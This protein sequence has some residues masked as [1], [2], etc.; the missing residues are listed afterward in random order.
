MRIAIVSTLALALAASGCKALGFHE[1]QKDITTYT[2]KA[3]AEFSTN[4]AK[5]EERIVVKKFTLDLAAKP[6]KAVMTL[7]NEGPDQDLFLA[8]VEFG[9]PAEAGSV[10]P[11]IPDFQSFARES[12]VK[13]AELEFTVPSSTVALDKYGPP[14]FARV[15]VTTGSS[16][17]MTTACEATSLGLKQG[18]TFLGGA[19][20][21]VDLE[22][23]LAAEKPN[24]RFTLQNVGDKGEIGTLMYTCQFFSRDGK[25]IP[26]GKRFYQLKALEKPLGKKGDK[27]TI[28]VNPTPDASVSLVG[29]K[30]VLFVTS[31]ATA[32]K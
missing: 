8:D 26:L 9:Y 11:Y 18:S 29:A 6:P 25:L 2:T 23:D 20:E 31:A 28:E 15:V 21:V 19:V 32:K 12:F 1:E 22:G 10:A 27:V 30:P 16:A 24:L 13:G 7:R 17:R 3:G 5:P 4:P 14:Q